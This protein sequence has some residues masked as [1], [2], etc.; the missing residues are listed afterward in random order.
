MYELIQA[1]GRTYYIDCP[2][3]M[4]VF[5]LDGGHAC[6]IDG[7]S[8]KDAAKKA[9]KLL[10]ARGWALSCVVNTHSHGDHIGG[11]QLLQNRTGCKIFAKG[12]ERAFTS[13][14]VLEP[15]FLYGGFPPS[16]LR[17]HFLEAAPS[18]VLP[19]EDPDFPRELEIVDLPGHS[20]DMIGLRTPDDVLFLADA[21]TSEET[22]EKYQVSFLYDVESYL[23]TLQTIERI[24]AKL[25]VPA[26][27]AATADI[28]PLARRN[29]EKVMQI[30]RYLLNVCQTPC[31]FEE[32]LQAVFAD[33][34]LTMDCNQYVLVGSTV[35]SYLAYLNNQQKVSFR[36]EANRML[37]ETV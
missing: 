16:A 28:A 33:F 26:H 17:N 36:F 23:S 7:G 12:V 25:F 35:R 3:K 2:V 15:A 29:R 24:Q 10:E 37:W 20:F 9:L 19:L 4:G 32:I 5:L 11:N 31:S 21:L 8:G 22:I 34:S 6:L 30:I 18:G 27:A 13:D 1:G 14:P